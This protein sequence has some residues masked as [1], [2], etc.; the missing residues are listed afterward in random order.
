MERISAYGKLP[1]G[2]LRYHTASSI[3][4][5]TRSRDEVFEEICEEHL[6]W[7]D[8]ALH[9]NDLDD[10]MDALWAEIELRG[11]IPKQA[12]SLIHLAKV[13]HIKPERPNKSSLLTIQ[14]LTG[15]IGV[16]LPGWGV[17]NLRRKFKLP[18]MNE[19]FL[20]NSFWESEVVLLHE[21]NRDKLDKAYLIYIEDSLGAEKVKDSP[22]SV[23]RLSASLA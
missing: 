22:L 20:R 16:F 8:K 21:F 18:R 2:V 14:D 11:G 12:R 4:D 10:R 17:K 15:S 1:A 23:L 6:L 13:N 9:S 19:A 3:Y 5:I 7:I